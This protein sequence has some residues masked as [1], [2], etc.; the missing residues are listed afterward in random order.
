MAFR[1]KKTIKIAGVKVNIGKNGISSI[2]IG[3]KGASL[4]IGKN[5]IHSNLGIPGTGLSYRSKLAGSTKKQKTSNKLTKSEQQQID[6][7][8][9]IKDSKDDVQLM[10]L[11]FL[12]INGVDIY[13]D[14]VAIENISIDNELI[15][16]FNTLELSFNRAI[17]EVEFSGDTGQ[18]A[19]N[20]ISKFVFEIK[21]WLDSNHPNWESE[22]HQIEKMIEKRITEQQEKEK[23]ENQAIKEKQF[24][25]IKFIFLFIFTF[26][27]P[28]IFCWFSL[29]KKYPLWFKVI[30]FSWALI[31][32]FIVLNKEK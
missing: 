5:G 31:I 22:K 17:S 8:C 4:N 13:S 6:F 11:C 23:A 28:M 2:S 10:K 14:D 20:K 7:E 15:N 30:S 26:F 1:F 9:F 32:T 27:F 29:Q 24:F 21:R 19:K 18:R 25:T 3:K 12:S 16:K